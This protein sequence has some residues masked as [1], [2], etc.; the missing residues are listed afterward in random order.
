MLPTK[1]LPER[2]GWGQTVFH[3]KIRVWEQPVEVATQE[4]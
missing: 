3:A 1:L 4:F 2:Q